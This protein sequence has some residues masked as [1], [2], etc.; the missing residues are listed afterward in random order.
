MLLLCLFIVCEIIRYSVSFSGL[1][2]LFKKITSSS[3]LLCVQLNS[4]IFGFVLMEVVSIFYF[5]F[6]NCLHFAL[7]MRIALAYLGMTLCSPPLNTVAICRALQPG[8]ALIQRDDQIHCLDYDA[9]LNS[10][11]F[12]CLA[13]ATPS[14]FPLVN[15]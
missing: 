12:S 15:S 6:V 5:L 11:L 1:L 10:L 2:L 4:W 14:C 13:L 3:S 9:S 7:I 8:T